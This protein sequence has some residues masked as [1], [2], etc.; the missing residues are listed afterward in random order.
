M[1]SLYLVLRRVK[2]G[3]CVGIGY[4]GRSDAFHRN[5]RKLA[6]QER[7]DRPKRR[8]IAAL[9]SA[10]ISSLIGGRKQA[11]VALCRAA[12]SCDGSQELN[13]FYSEQLGVDYRRR[14]VAVRRQQ[15]A[16][17]ASDP[18]TDRSQPVVASCR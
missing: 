3:P 14:S 9:V 18:A 1:F 5:C 16:H 8:S 6:R 11:H 17:V 2:V 15:S 4:K 7:S 12:T 10:A 13:T